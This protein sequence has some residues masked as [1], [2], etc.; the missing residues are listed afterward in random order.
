MPIN[1]LLSSIYHHQT[2]VMALSLLC[3]GAIVVSLKTGMQLLFVL[4]KRSAPTPPRLELPLQLGQLGF[5]K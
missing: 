2:S 1:L 5:K 4:V 3:D